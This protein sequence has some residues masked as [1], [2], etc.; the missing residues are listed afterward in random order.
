MR[1]AVSPPFSSKFPKKDSLCTT[2]PNSSRIVRSAARRNIINDASAVAMRCDTSCAVVQHSNGNSM[3]FDAS[4]T[5]QC[6]INSKYR[7]SSPI[8][9]NSN[10]S[11]V[12]SSMPCCM[13][14]NIHR[15]WCEAISSRCVVSWEKRI[16]AANF[17]LACISMVVSMSSKTMPSL[18]MS[19]IVGALAAVLRGGVAGR[20]CGC[21]GGLFHSTI[22][23]DSIHCFKCCTEYN[24]ASW[25]YKTMA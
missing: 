12:A 19:R 24:C 9:I 4:C 1:C 8:Q 25:R 20:V 3:G 14:C 21:C 15:R 16:N 6:W 17:S 13:Y 11:A 23:L 7:Y 2:F 10:R 22:R 5:A 18:A